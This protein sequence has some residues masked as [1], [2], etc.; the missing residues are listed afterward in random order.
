E[1]DRLLNR[2]SGLKGLSEGVSD[3]QRLLA[4]ADSGEPRAIRAINVFSY[5]AKKYI[6]S[7]MAALGHVDAIIFTGGIGE[8]AAPIRAAICEGLENIGIEI[9]RKA[10]NDASRHP[11]IS[12]D[13]SA[14]EI[15]VIPT[16]EELMIAL[17]TRRIV[18]GA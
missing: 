4:L 10:N 12:S 1:V 9:D 13:A 18:R 14:V 8:N 16:N 7:Y 11:R 17:D 6:G 5:R 15:L 3:M 2:E